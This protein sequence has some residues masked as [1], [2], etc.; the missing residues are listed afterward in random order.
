[1]RDDLRYGDMAYVLW[2]YETQTVRDV[3]SYEQAVVDVGAADEPSYALEDPW[4]IPTPEEM[5]EF[6]MR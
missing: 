2:D 1:M 3:L 4:D 5:I 6:C